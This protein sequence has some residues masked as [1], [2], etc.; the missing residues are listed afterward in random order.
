MLEYS[1]LS[2]EGIKINLCCFVFVSFSGFG[3][4]MLC[5]Y[6]FVSNF[7]SHKPHCRLSFFWLLFSWLCLT[8]EQSK[9]SDYPPNKCI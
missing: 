3:E 1:S 5:T 2:F 8:S 7:S 9:S 6:P 4:D